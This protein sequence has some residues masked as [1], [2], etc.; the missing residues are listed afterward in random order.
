[1]AVFNSRTA[2]CFSDR[3]LAVPEHRVR[4]QLPQMPAFPQAGPGG[5]RNAASARQ[6]DAELPGERSSAPLRGLC[7]DRRLLDR[8][9]TFNLSLPAKVSTALPRSAHLHFLRCLEQLKLLSFA[10][11]IAFCLLVLQT[12]SLP[13]LPCFYVV[14]P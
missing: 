5:G 10:R 1:M 8:T 7:A 2:F 6:R 11:Y 9:N 14:L 4:L 12:S 3:F 13:S